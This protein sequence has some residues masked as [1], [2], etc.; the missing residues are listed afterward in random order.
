MYLKLYDDTYTNGWEYDGDRGTRSDP[1]AY[2]AVHMRLYAPYPED[3][4]YDYSLGYFVLG[5]AHIDIL[6]GIAKLKRLLR[7]CYAHGRVV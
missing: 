4:F 7:I 1:I 6:P 2:P 3:K 5:I